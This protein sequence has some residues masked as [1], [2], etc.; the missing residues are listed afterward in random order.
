MIAA[1]STGDFAAGGA[2]CDAA[3]E[4]TCVEAAAYR[5]VGAVAGA[6]SGVFVPVSGEAAEAGEAA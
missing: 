3:E 4:A 6:A 5:A 2:D 1:T